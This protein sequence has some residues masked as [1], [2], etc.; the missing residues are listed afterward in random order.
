M[1]ERKNVLYPVIN[2]C[3]FNHLFSGALVS[4]LKHRF[5][6]PECLPLEDLFI[7]NSKTNHELHFRNFRQ[8][9]LRFKR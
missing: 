4:F 2:A 6:A 7:K 8:A 9:N 5:F 3:L 1:I